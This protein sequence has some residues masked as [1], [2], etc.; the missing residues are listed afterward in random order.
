MSG[1]KWDTAQTEKPDVGAIS[2]ARQNK[3]LLNTDPV[4]SVCYTQ[5][6]QATLTSAVASGKTRLMG[7]E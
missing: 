6:H 4:T 7:V 1:A 3:S 5:V 2:T